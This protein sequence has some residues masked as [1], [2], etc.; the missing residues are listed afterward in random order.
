MITD[1]PHLYLQQGLSRG[2]PRELVERALQEAH[3]VEARGLTSVLT[4][5][6]LAHQTGAPYPYL[7]Q[8]VERQHDPYRS[9]QVPKRDGKHRR[10]ISTPEPTLMWVQK[11][12]LRRILAKAQVHPAS[13]A[14][15]SGKS[16]KMCAG[17]HAG[18]NWLVKV[19]L[20]DF[21]ETIN[22]VKV[23]DAFATMGYARLPSLEMARL[24]TRYAG[25]ATH[26][27]RGSYVAMDRRYDAIPRYRTSFIGFLP[28]G[29]P[30]SGALANCVAY[31]LDERLAGLA[32][33]QQMIYT[34]Y[35][36]DI[37]F[38]SSAPFERPAAVELIRA[39]DQIAQGSGFLLHRKKIRIV[40]P[41]ARKLVLGLLVD[42]DAPRLTKETRGR[43]ANHVRGVQQF[44]LREHTR[45][46]GFSS[47]RGLVHYVDGLLAFAHDIE[48]EWAQ[49]LKQQWKEALASHGWRIDLTEL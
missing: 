4:L 33:S 38:S 27:N 22:E 19:D 49:P 30:T 11:W 28:Q 44:G 40:P 18:A 32:A 25:H 16:I 26:V 42:R 21:F 20:H 41:G 3:R 13:Y 46:R 7:R 17:S 5:G 24:C 1:S 9:F 12:L 47:L 31:R 2:Y 43:I 36:D 6:H 29:A 45:H 37:T 23:F 14:Y 8:V 39:V 35:A 10:V 34:R 15:Q 48:P